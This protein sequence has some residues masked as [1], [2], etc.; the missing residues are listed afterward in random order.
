M[1]KVDKKIF[2]SISGGA[3][4]AGEQITIG[5]DGVGRDRITI[6]EEITYKVACF[7]NPYLGLQSFTYVDYA[8]YAGREKM[9]ER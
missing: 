6:T 7:A 5:G 8:K 1:E 4:L 2:R 3:N 9:K